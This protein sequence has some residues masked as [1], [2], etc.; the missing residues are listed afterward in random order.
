[1]AFLDHKTNIAI[2]CCG[3]FTVFVGC[4][5]VEAQ[6]ICSE[7]EVRTALSELS[8]VADGA[9]LSPTAI[10]NQI[11]DKCVNMETEEE[12]N[13]CFRKTLKRIT[14]AFRDLSRANFLDRDWIFA[15][16]SALFDLQDSTCSAISSS[17]DEANDPVRDL[18][19]Q[20][21]P[22]I[23][24]RRRRAR[25]TRIEDNGFTSRNR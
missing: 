24:N 13:R 25:D 3:A 19:N 18:S 10:A 22:S 12:C 1:M 7:A 14:K 23:N 8:C 2:C 15:V 17:D 9:Y 5:R 20:D 11:G 6:E 21:T 16:R 4:Q